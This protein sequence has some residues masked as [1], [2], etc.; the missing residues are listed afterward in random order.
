MHTDDNVD[1]T[2]AVPPGP[3]PV[4]SNIVAGKRQAEE[5][6]SFAA[7]NTFHATKQL[8]IVGGVSYDINNVLEV[9]PPLVIGPSR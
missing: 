9:T 2:Y 3:S 7:E 6:W 5:T 1:F 4:S 8:D